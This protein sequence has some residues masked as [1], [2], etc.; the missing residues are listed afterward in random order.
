LIDHQTIV[1]N[2]IGVEGETAAAGIASATAKIVSTILWENDLSIASEILPALQ[3]S[4]SD[5]LGNPVGG[6]GNIEMDPLFVNP[7]GGN[8]RLR[9]ESPCVGTGEL[10]TDMGAFPTDANGRSLMRLR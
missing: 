7:M 5:I 8:Y 3:I 2:E 4:F 6:E 1:H 10:G 9:P